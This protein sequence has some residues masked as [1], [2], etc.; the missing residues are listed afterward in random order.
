MAAIGSEAP[1]V[2][3][4]I[5]SATFEGFGLKWIVHPGDPAFEA[6][7]KAAVNRLLGKFVVE[8]AA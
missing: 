3:A 1:E 7:L 8:G 2:D 6:R 5:L 4:D